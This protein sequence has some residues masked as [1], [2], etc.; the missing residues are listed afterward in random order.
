MDVILDIFSTHLFDGNSLLALSISGLLGTGLRYF[1]VA[2]GLGMVIFFHELG[3]YGIAKWC[4]VFVER[5]SIGFGPVLWSRKWGETEYALSAIPFGGYVKML[6]QDDMDPSQLSQEEIAEDPRSYSAKTVGQ[7]MAIISAGVI[8]NL[9]TAAL[10]F[11]I[12]FSLGVE[13]PAPVIGIVQPG[14]PAW[15]AGVLPGDT[16]TKINGR[17]ATTF[18]DILYGVALSSKNVTLEGH[19]TDG[20]TFNLVIG[21]DKSGSR[22]Q[23]GVGPSRSTMLAELQDP[24]KE[25]VRRGTAAD[26]TT[27]SFEQKDQVLKVG[28]VEIKSFAQL[29]AVLAQQKDQTRKILV[30]RLQNKLTRETA[31]ILIEVE[32]TPFRTLGLMVECGKITAVQE[33]SPAQA[34]GMKEGDKPIKIDGQ[35]VGTKLNS[36]YL[37]D[38]FWNHRNDKIEM[39]VRREIK[40]S[41]AKEITLLFDPKEKKKKLLDRPG[42]MSPFVFQDGPLA[43]PAA[44]FTFELVPTVLKVQPDSPA[45]HAGIQPTDRL[46]KIEF[47]VPEEEAKKINDKTQTESVTYLFSEDKKKNIV[48]TNNYAVPFA[49]MQ[50]FLEYHVR[51]TY[52][53][54][55]E[56]KTVVLVPKSWKDPSDPKAVWNYPKIGIYPAPEMKKLIAADPIKTLR[57]GMGYTRNSVIRMYLTF[58][59]LFRGDLSVKEFSGPLGIVGIAYKVT[60]QG[61][62]MFLLFLGI[63]S[64]NL[65]VINFLPIPVLDGGHMVFLIWE[66][67]TRKKPNEKV[68]NIATYF[69]FAFIISLMALVIYLDIDRMTQ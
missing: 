18:E 5:F 35:D 55:G 26:K 46:R 15:K 52:T 19:H 21:P 68:I 66:G 60:A 20:T 56:E 58:G 53:R 29:Q 7:R 67:V 27:V 64:I 22:P 8:M 51:L 50:L 9:I 61:V 45:F 40:G 36:L 59:S 11:S 62:A 16:I 43:V 44:G 33:G 30:R 39:V 1:Y 69:G 14:S 10:F 48:S 31:D 3:H 34:A 41:E 2:M 24:E 38:Y 49:G 4:G 12:A 32:P 54:E 13:M 6:G 23:I 63:L 65:A 57:M 25:P 47:F 17:E 28:E 37:P 42:W